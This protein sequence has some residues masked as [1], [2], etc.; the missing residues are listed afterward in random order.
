MDHIETVILADLW[1]TIL[2]RFNAT[3]QSVQAEDIELS[4]VVKL[5]ESLKS[6]LKSVHNDF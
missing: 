5:L 4:L 2:D 3:I 6:H 1:D